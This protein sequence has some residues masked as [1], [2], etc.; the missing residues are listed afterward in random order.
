MF[1]YFSKRGKAEYSLQEDV[2]LDVSE[3]INLFQ[4]SNIL[5]GTKVTTED[6]IKVLERYYTPGTR[7]EDKL[8]EKNFTE[9]LA[10][11][12]LLLPVN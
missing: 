6:F 10:G 5:D 4:K 8:D 2:T 9:L 1:K 7:L 3:A 12:P 11:N